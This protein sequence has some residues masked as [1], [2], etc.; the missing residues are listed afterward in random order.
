M[1]VVTRFTNGYPQLSAGQGYGSNAQ[2]SRAI[3]KDSFFK[4]AAV[5]GDS[6]ASIYKLGRLPSSALIL[7][8]SALYC[9]AIAGLTSVS[10]GLDNTLGTVLAN[11]LVTAVNMAAGG[12]FP[13][14]SNVPIANYDQRVW[15]LLGL[16]SDPGA[17]IDVNLSLG[18]ALTASG[19]LTGHIFWT[20][21]AV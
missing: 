18:A 2:E 8:Q 6:I 20:N 16:A 1:A 7:P 17:L 21:N 11:A 15:Q 3:V 5:N 10:V 14:V 12:T 13:L 4:I 9:G 19:P